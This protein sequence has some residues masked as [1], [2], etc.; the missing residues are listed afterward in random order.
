[1]KLNDLIDKISTNTKEA[2]V[3]LQKLLPMEFELEEYKTY[4]E[5]NRWSVTNN[6]LWL[7]L[8][9]SQDGE[10]HWCDQ[11]SINVD[12]KTIWLIRKGLACYLWESEFNYETEKPS[13]AF[14]K[15]LL[16]GI[17]KKQ[18]VATHIVELI[19]SKKRVSQYVLNQLEKAEG[20]LTLEQ[21]NKIIKY[22][23]N[24]DTYEY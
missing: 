1:M 14:M 16:S 8:R 3:E 9:T 6:G 23:S 15:M 13:A 24:K 4:I 18:A 19:E 12:K 11:L 5:E 7:G 17:L 2:I 22:L 21:A 20:E 10:E